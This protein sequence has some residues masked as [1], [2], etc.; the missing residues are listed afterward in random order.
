MG[1]TSAALVRP[2]PNRMPQC[3]TGGE[4]GGATAKARDVV[5]GRL[6][7]EEVVAHGARGPHLGRRWGRSCHQGG[8]GGGGG[9]SSDLE[10]GEEQG[11]CA[12]TRRRTG[13]GM[14][15]VGVAMVDPV[16]T[17]GSG[18]ADPTPEGL[19]KADPAT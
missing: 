2:S 13:I 9:E 1:V 11:G 10:G 14:R 5:G 4:A 12:G 8:G 6:G 17:V 19:G 16:V 15:V 7:V 3:Q 18:K